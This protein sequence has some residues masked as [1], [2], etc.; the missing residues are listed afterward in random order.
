MNLSKLHGILAK[1]C[2]II[3]RDSKPSLQMLNKEI[4][5]G[6]HLAQKKWDKA[7]HIIQ[8][9]QAATLT[10]F[11]Y[12][13]T[14]DGIHRFTTDMVDCL[15]NHPDQGKQLPDPFAVAA[16]IAFNKTSV[17]HLDDDVMK[18][19]IIRYLIELEEYDEIAQEIFE[20]MPEASVE[21][22]VEKLRGNLVKAVI[23]SLKPEELGNIDG[24]LSFSVTMN[25]YAMTGDLQLLQQLQ[26]RLDELYE[27]VD[28]E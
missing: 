11:G 24:W 6:I 2:S 1:C 9:V 20:R 19:V 17:G 7:I 10:E 18:R 15:K 5:N 12:D 23:E 22:R 27:I 16:S 4:P 13:V 14:Q 26:A 3:Q 28:T 21:E 25:T 8:P